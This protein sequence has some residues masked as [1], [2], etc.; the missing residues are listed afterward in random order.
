MSTMPDSPRKQI[1]ARLRQNKAAWAGGGLT[2]LFLV[3][4]LTADWIA[5]YS[6]NRTFAEVAERP[7]PQHWLGTDN[8]RKDVL[9]RVIHGARLSLLAGTLSIALATAIGVPLGA[10]AGYFSGPVDAILMRLVDVAL[11]FPS[12]LIALVCAAAFRPGWTTVIVAVALINVPTFAR[13]IRATVLTVR[14]L[15]YVVASRAFGAGPWRILRTEILPSLLNPILVLA[16]LG[17]GAAILE[18]AGLS[19]L[20]IGGDLTEPEWGGMLSQAKD[21]W[22]KNVWF[23]IGPGAAISAAVLGFNLLGDA[24]RDALDP[25][26]ELFRH[27]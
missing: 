9:S 23:A 18:T 12:V 16:S 4:A 24:L 1:L 19:F 22:S 27:D 14:H 15:D 26:R 6:P 11:A 2:L 13:Q 7:S 17:I 10:V 3:F 8:L 20:G 25:R 21:Y 5:P